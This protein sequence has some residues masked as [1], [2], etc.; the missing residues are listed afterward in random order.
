MMPST[1]SGGMAWNAAPLVALG[2]PL[3]IV[4]ES[5]ETS[6]YENG[7]D[8]PVKPTAAHIELLIGVGTHTILAEIRVGKGMSSTHKTVEFF[9]EERVWMTAS[10]E[11][12][13]NSHLAM[14]RELVTADEPEMQLGLHD[15]LKVVRVCDDGCRMARELPA[16]T[17]GQTPD[18]LLTPLRTTSLV[19]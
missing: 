15:V 4:I 8:Q 7:P 3:E 11:K 5:A 9:R 14:I 13:E 18:W 1:I 12:S 2:L 6:T 10:L 17:F 19:G 16:Y